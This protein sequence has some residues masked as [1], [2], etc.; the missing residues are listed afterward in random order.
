MKPTFLT[1]GRM[2]KVL[3]ALYGVGR[4][5]EDC[6]LRAVSATVETFLRSIDCCVSAPFAFRSFL[7]FFFRP[8]NIH[9]TTLLFDA[10]EYVQS[11]VRRV[12]WGWS[13]GV[14]LELRFI[15]CCVSAPF[16]FRNLRD[17]FSSTEHPRQFGQNGASN[18]ITSRNA[19]CSGDRKSWVGTSHCH[20]FTGRRHPF[21]RITPGSNAR[22]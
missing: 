7:G 19:F 1:P 15:D 3:F 20:T 18:A 16:A 9:E 22:S 17:F 13:E 8:R 14:A 11:T 5:V 12:R 2:Y 21:P 4:Q 10:W 6:N